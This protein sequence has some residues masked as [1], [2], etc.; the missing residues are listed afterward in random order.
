M[1]LR[2]RNIPLTAFVD[3]DYDG[4]NFFDGRYHFDAVADLDLMMDV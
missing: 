3:D 1:M 2:D 4:S